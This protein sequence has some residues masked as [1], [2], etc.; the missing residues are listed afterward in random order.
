MEMLN[1]TAASGADGTACATGAADEALDVGASDAGPPEQPMG[2]I[3]AANNTSRRAQPRRSEAIVLLPALFISEQPLENHIYRH[4][5]DD[6]RALAHMIAVGNS[7]TRPPISGNL[8]RN[9]TGS[10]GGSDVLGGC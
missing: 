6:G 2:R 10:K 4:R 3:Q 8:R 9:F 1:V 7:L 5:F